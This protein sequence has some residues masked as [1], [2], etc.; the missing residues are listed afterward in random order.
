M[1]RKRTQL[2][3]EYNAHLAHHCKCL[4]CGTEDQDE[5]TDF[6]RLR[7][8]RVHCCR[9][10]AVRAAKKRQGEERAVRAKEKTRMIP[11]LPGEMALEHWKD[12]TGYEVCV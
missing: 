3:F 12:R 10:K 9:C 5:F 1:G 11:I 8:P 7:S 2:I 6:D 4:T